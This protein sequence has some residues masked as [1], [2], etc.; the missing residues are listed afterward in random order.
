MA[1]AQRRARLTRLFDTVLKGTTS[2]G[3]PAQC[4][5]FIEAICSQPDP[6]LCIE[7]IIASEHGIAALQAAIRADLSIDTLNKHAVDL[8]IFLQNPA[9]KTLSR[10]QLLTRVLL[11]IVEPPTFW[12]EFVTA[13]KEHKLR[14]QGQRC[15]AWVLLQLILIPGEEESPY[16]PIAKD[17]KAALLLSS[18]L[19]V[20]SLGKHIE[21]TVS[22]SSSSSPPG[23]SDDISPG[24]RHDNDFP[25]FR[26]IAILPTADELRSKELPFLRPAAVLDDPSSIEQR[27]AIY[28]DN[29][30]RLLREDMISEMREELQIALGQTGRKHRGFVV[31][32][33][34]VC[35]CTADER[36]KWSI[37]L[38]CSKDLP[39]LE[40]FKKPLERMKAITSNPKL[41]KHQSLASLI[42]D[43]EIVAFPSVHRD[44]YRLAKEP[45]EIVLEVEGEL[46]V[47]KLLLKLKTA[48]R[49]KLIQIDV[50][51]FAYEPILT[52]L[53]SMKTLPL[54]KEL[55]FWKEGEPIG[56]SVLHPRLQHA[57]DRQKRHRG[58]D[59][60]ALLTL[61]HPVVLD[62]TQEEAF[63]SGLTQDLS[64]IQGPPGTGKSFIGA[65]LAKF[66]HDFSDLKIL[67]VCFTN[68]ALDQFLEDVLDIGVVQ[69]SMVRIGGKSTARTEPM[70]LQKQTT[71]FRFSRADNSIINSLKADVT[72]HAHTL[73]GAFKRYLNSKIDT[74]ELLAFLEFEEPTY[75]DAFQV[76]MSNDGMQTVGSRGQAVTETYLVDLWRLGKGAGIFSKSSNV[77]QAARIWSLPKQGRSELMDEWAQV[78]R[79]DE[80]EELYKTALRYN[81]LVGE[82]TRKFRE[83]DGA[84]LKSKRIIG[85]TTTA[86]AKYTQDILAAAPDVVLVEEA[87]EIL[88]SHVITAL[89]EAAKKL[90]LIGDH[91]QLRPKV[92]SYN[93]TVEKGEG[94]D[95]N[96]SLFERLV[97]KGY[98]HHTLRSQHRMRPEISALVRHLTY[99]D[100]EDAPKTLNR[101]NIR[102]LQDNII[103]INHDQPEDELQQIS[104]MRDFGSKS[105]KQN[106][107]EARM[108][109]KTV[110]YLAQQGYG[111]EKMVVLTPYLGQ[112]H[113]LQG[114]LRAET[115]PVLNDL[116][117]YDLIRA[118]LVTPGAAKS[119]KRQLRL[120][121]IDN[122]QGEE[123]DIVIASL[124]RSN[125]N[126]NIGFMCAPERLNVLLSRARN[127]L[128]MIGNSNTFTQSKTG[129]ELWKRLFEKMQRHIYNGLPVECQQHPDR[130]ALICHEGDFDQ[131]CPDGGCSEHC[132]TILSCGIHKCPSKCHQLYDHSKMRCEAII[133][134]QCLKGH[135]LSRKCS[136]QPIPG[137]KKC[138]REVALEEAKRQKEFARQ[139]KREE[140]EAEH[141]RRKKELDEKMAQ[142]Q[143][144]LRDVQLKRERVN[145]LQQKRVDLDEAT[146]FRRRAEMQAE[147]RS[148]PSTTADVP[149]TTGVGSRRTDSPPAQPPT[150]TTV[151]SSHAKKS[152]EPSRG[153]VTSPTGSL[154]SPSEAR[155]QHKKSIEG[156]SNQAIDAIMEM[157]GLEDVKKQI[158]RILDKIDVS[159]RQGVPFDKERYNLVLLGNPGTGKTTIA[160][161][162]AKYLSSVSILPGNAFEETTGSR[163]ASDGTKG[164]KDLIDKVKNAGGGAIFVDEAYQLASGHNFQGAQV[165]DFLLAEMENNVGTIVFLL[166]GYNKQMEKFFEHNPG[167][168][169]RVPYRFQFD[170]YTDDEL[171]HMLGKMIHRKYSGRMKVVDGV[172]GLYGRIVARRLGRGRGRDGFGN[173][174][175]LENLLSTIMDRQAARIASQR[176]AGMRP[177][178]LLL[179][180]EDLI[181]PDPSTAIIESESWKKLQKL[182]GLALVKRSIQDL[183]DM[184]KRNYARELREEEPLAVS[185]NRTFIGSPGTG[186]TTVAKLYGRILSDLGLLSNGEVVVKNPADFIGSALGESENKTKAIL[187][188]TVG[189]VLIIDEAY[190]LHTGGPTGQQSDPYKTSVIDTLV[191][192]VQSTVGEDRCVLLLGYEKEMRE[193]FQAVNPGLSR[194]FGIEDAFKF[195]DFTSDELLEILNLKLQQQNL[196][197]TPEAKATAIEVLNRSKMRPNFGNGGEVENMLGKAKTNFMNRVRGTMQDSDTVVFQAAD[198]DPDYNRSVQAQDKLSDLFQDVVGCEEIVRKLSSFQKIA[199]TGHKRGEDIGDLSCVG[200]GKTT[201][202]RKMGE[203]YYDMGLLGRAIVHECSASDLVAQY[204]GQTG[205]LVRKMFEKG[206]G[207]VLFIDEAYRLKDG[208]FAKEATD[209]I[210]TLLTDERYKGKIVVIL[211]GY[212]QD[213]NELLAANRGLSSRFTEEV[214][215]HHL[216]PSQCIQIL[217]TNLRRKLVHIPDLENSSSNAYQTLLRIFDEFASLTSWG[218]ARDVDKTCARGSSQ[219]IPLRSGQR[220]IASPMHAPPVCAHSFKTKSNVLSSQ[221]PDEEAPT[222]TATDIRDAGVSD[223]VWM[224]LKMAK[225][226]AEAEENRVREEI[227]DA[228]KRASQAKQLELEAKARGKLLAQALAKEKDRSK[229]DEMKRLREAQRLK[230]VEAMRRREQIEEELRARRDAEKKAKQQEAQAQRKLREMGVCV[231]GFRWIRMESGIAAPGGRILCPM[232][233]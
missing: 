196:D 94:Y 58:R 124:T 69:K 119:T 14:E 2:L 80:V 164:A 198:F 95:L 97:L 143:Q 140:E 64:L 18:H 201:T 166:A 4:K 3:S 181:G 152:T 206:L 54:S 56:H 7:R 87:G 57:I 117:S 231:A 211:A 159:V 114:E 71:D 29:M 191:A 122:Y 53:K 233:N 219:C 5:Q 21:H 187:A 220:A 51:V 186:K 171:R 127:G 133:P 147:T 193:M 203:V 224:E 79:K 85:C 174:R 77:R 83:K 226:A 215:F 96:R 204:V 37:I 168:T 90:I 61:P 35:D 111:T 50:A 183:Y 173:A 130:K 123:S 129:G 38:R 40:K 146:A 74:V 145:E 76:P 118:G 103:F 88:E 11:A 128:I 126:N 136:N 222:K 17:V 232:V 47:R 34:R 16:L 120:A 92:N 176:S 156:V 112:L 86:A 49:V 194:R 20:R 62:P 55:L 142:E 185:L 141:L 229:Q 43:G 179:V 197:A 89:G 84:I 12:S 106:H 175:A 169:S 41:L 163:L 189:K 59:L 184:I 202:A 110:R 22:V 27:E 216:L 6:P 131:L 39:Q 230:E 8:I 121:T 135:N 113:L 46:A 162:Y 98:P 102:G 60:K 28:I 160:R 19:D 217:D 200:T 139:K 65:L 52:A 132:G 104:E 78:M 180:K 158:L 195:E 154:V 205:P 214:L 182:T 208:P 33:L 73:T 105:S 109:L 161:H 23:A 165:L 30:F 144:I 68:H 138:D 70:L 137:C 1:D 207:Q 218:N 192:E 228:Q 10:G 210:V 190:M 149:L 9:I 155:W 99:P 91:K 42:V 178:D 148:T 227:E 107:Y 167:L 115:D 48:E 116:D 67:V 31:D 188:N 13:F 151:P 26:D 36:R 72:T 225:T 24:G 108:V 157:T 209:E 153:N 150:V 213:I 66:I 75:F 223:A 199:A 81:K 125:P 134:H 100:L 177:D 221:A 172:D 93:L 212:D 25:N 63:L 82:L 15:F 101:P 44:E 45:P 32:G 170:D